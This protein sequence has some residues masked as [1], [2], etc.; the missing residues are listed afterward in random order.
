MRATATTRVAE[1]RQAEAPA[2]HCYT[3][4]D[5][6]CGAG[7]SACRRFLNRRSFLLAAIGA[8][9]CSR[10]ELAPGLK[11]AVQ[12]LWARQAEDGG[13][14]SHTYGLLRSGQSLTPFVLDA[15]LEIP[16]QMRAAPP[17]SVDRALGFIR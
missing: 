14:H 16:E 1:E 7:A 3:S 10:S 4:T 9:G 5:E 6:S 11:K 17:A 15:L 12:Y 8:A 2:P 13:W